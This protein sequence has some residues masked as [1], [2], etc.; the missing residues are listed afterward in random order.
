MGKET[1]G[2]NIDL[3]A[4]TIFAE[5]QLADKIA[6]FKTWGKTRE[7]DTG[8]LGHLAF[9]GISTGTQVEIADKNGSGSFI[10]GEYHINTGQIG[11]K[12]VSPKTERGKTGITPTYLL[13][14]LVNTSQIICDESCPWNSTAPQEPSELQ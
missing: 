5:E 2:T 7:N 6:Y 9:H 3:A 4:K 10:L 1:K 12:R 11:L 14:R 8:V 13:N